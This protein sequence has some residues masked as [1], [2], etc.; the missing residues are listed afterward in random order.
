MFRDNALRIPL[1][2]PFLERISTG[3]GLR[4]SS[5]KPELLRRYRA[6]EQVSRVVEANF[7]PGSQRSVSVVVLAQN[8]QTGRFEDWAVCQ[9]RP[10][11]SRTA[12]DLGHMG[13]QTESWVPPLGG[14]ALVLLSVYALGLLVSVRL[15]QEIVAVIDSLSYAALQVGGGDFSVRVAV[16]E[17]DQLGL[18]ASSF[19]QM[20]SDLKTLREQEKQSAALE[21]DIAFDHEVQQYLYPLVTP[22]L[23]AANVSGVTKPVRIVGGDL[24]DFLRFSNSQVGLL[25]A[26]VSGKGVSAALM[27]AHLQALARGRLLPTNET[28]M[29]PAPGAFVTALNREFQ[30]RSGIPGTSPCSTA[31]LIATTRC[32]AM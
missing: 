5:S 21:R 2:D 4:V 6:H 23:A 8:W 29:R 25:C 20:T 24:Y 14:L 9:I 30:G 31:N 26:D 19:N 32:F 27:M 22:A 17:Q 16:P 28:T 7:I 3:S 11:Y 15:S 18:L 13:M 1:T 10:S 12:E